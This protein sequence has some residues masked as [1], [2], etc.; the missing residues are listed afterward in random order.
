VLTDLRAHLWVKAW[1]NLAF[2]PISALTRASLAE[3]CADSK[4]RALATQV[5]Q[6]AAE[7]ADKIG[8]RLRIS[9]EQRIEGAAAVGEHKTSMLQDVE[10]RRELEIEPLVGSFVELG[11]LT[12]T[13]TPA[14]DVLYALTSLLNA[15]VTKGVS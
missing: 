8:L 5:M 1:G 11:R 12:E 3:I 10:A 2:N 15:A 14:T 6:E 4:T 9:I 7:I 13:P